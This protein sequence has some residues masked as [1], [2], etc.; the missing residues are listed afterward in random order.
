MPPPASTARPA[1]PPV[2][3]VADQ[4]TVVLSPFEVTAGGDT[5]YSAA[6]T[7]AG[8]R[9]NTDLR[10]VGSA[11]SVVTAQ[12]LQDL[13]ATD[14]ESL[15]Q[16]T[17]N[18]EI[19]NIY[20]TMAN[21]GS[22][23]QLDETSKFV[24]P[25]TNTRVRGLASA[26][27]TIDF[28]LTDMPWDSYNVDRV[29]FQRGPNAILF[30]LGSP[31]GIINASTK[32]AGFKNKGQVEVRYSKFNSLRTALDLNYVLRPKELAARINLLDND[33]KYQQ[34]PAFQH[35]RR[36]AAALRY[37]PE[38]VNRGMAHTT[39][40]ANFEAGRIRS[41]RPRSLPPGDAL[42]PWFYTGTTTGY[43]AD[44][45]TRAF[46]NLNKFG[47]D[48]R[49]DA[50]QNVTNLQDPTRGNF[51]A[52]TTIG[53]VTA[54]NPYWQPWLGGQFSSN[55]FGNPMAIFES[56]GSGARFFA[57]EPATPRGINSLGVID[58]T[59]GGIPNTRMASITIYRDVSKK[60]NLPG[61]NQGLTR[62]IM[63]TDPSIFDFYNNLIDGPNK[64]EWQ[65][66]KRFNLNLSQTFLRGDVGFEVV[67]D[68]QS[69]DNGQLTFMSDKDQNI[70][71]D[72]V[73]ILNDGSANPNFGRPFI[74]A[75][76]T[77]N[78]TTAYER[79]SGRATVF[80]KYD[81]AKGKPESLFMRTLGRH[82][83]TGFMN[84]D[85]AHRDNR[86][87]V[88]WTTDLAYK[89]FVTNPT[90][91]ATIDSSTRAVFPVIYLGPSLL[92]R[93][94]ASGAN[95]P[96]PMT[97]AVPVSSAIRAFDSTWAPPPGV[98]PGDPW[99][100]TNFVVGASGR[101]STQSENPANYKGWV[102][103]PITVIDSENGNRDA[104]TKGASL[105][106]NTVSSKAAVWN[107]YF[108]DGA[109]VAM[110]GVRRDTSKA[111][112][113]TGVRNTLGQINLSPSTYTISG[114]P[115][116]RID[117]T[118]KSWSVVGHLSQLFGRERLPLDVSV[119]YNKSE[120]F[121]AVAGRV[122]PFNENLGAP[123]GNTK[124]Y[125]VV[126]AT[127]SG[128]YSLKINKYESKSKNASSSGFN[129]FYL[130]Q[131]FQD[132][133]PSF[134]VWKYKIDTGFDLTTTQGQDPTRWTWLPGAGQT[135]QQATTDEAAS[136]AAWDTMVKA[137]PKEFL[138]AYNFN[139]DQVRQYAD[140]RDPTGLT[141]T[142]DNV[143][144]GYEAE[145]YAQPISNLRL[146]FNASKAEAV[147]SN[148]GEP[149]IVGL[150]NQINTALNTTAAGLMRNSTSGAAASALTSW[151][152]NLYASYIS[153][154]NQ[155]GGAVPELRKWR[156]NFI[157]NYDFRQGML[158]GVNIGGGLRWQDKAIVGYVPAYLDGSGKP[159]AWNPN[160]VKAATLL[161]DQPY[162]A[163]AETNIDAW[164]GYHRQLTKKVG[165]RTQL[166][167]T[168]V[169]KHDG[170]I[171]VT[172]Q[173]DGTP[174]GWRI[175]PTMVWRLTNTFDF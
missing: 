42:T 164:I 123:Q 125:G 169:G 104:N 7:L 60:E 48:A 81:F 65:N 52:N 116:D 115:R 166:N 59:I 67:Y 10:D 161:L 118:S 74:A 130:R 173:P 96:R 63:I 62:N 1:T 16:Y 110:Y 97:A 135:A 69:Y 45:T 127:K 53:G 13:S 73:R 56:D 87:F 140:A 28:F 9:L 79:H 14:N 108:W 32:Q 85:Y 17:T 82:I 36:F 54:P 160:N 154:K 159:I 99:T 120:N 49:G 148:V 57:A 8:N 150:V 109:L 174:A 165:F 71:I 26:D 76:D 88:R 90:S 72:V 2:T 171:P 83:L 128:N 107:G 147:R 168:N 39:F 4:E 100:N 12:M 136:I 31:A 92:S 156:A 30:G 55:Y 162:Y 78:N 80:A 37:E 113:Y 172:V 157:A 158:K 89:D 131:I 112:S 143:S 46:N 40:K 70:F 139:F 114:N 103:T 25:N 121:Q 86:S 133:Q 94:T 119:F 43:N 84:Q 38:L 20:G 68:H 19:G 106:Q 144:K 22:G 15:L 141:I 41:N 64:Q 167:I 91:V 134:N 175:A 152:N 34:R 77:N 75:P 6:T 33:E 58:G 3:T 111:W 95:I 155:E 145:L 151:N 11:I 142:E 61:A 138:T 146:T 50:D 47:I 35:D 153:I 98:N 51:N 105:T 93:T 117:A 137:L 24:A 126:F 66:F 149:S 29:D 124:D 129:I 5:G 170:L 23:T 163:P 102:N 44:G 18:T 101:N 21:A 27:N 122:G 132:Y